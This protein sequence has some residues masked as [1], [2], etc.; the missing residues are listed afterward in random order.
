MTTARLSPRR[1][2][3]VAT[4]VESFVWGVCLSSMR[5][6]VCLASPLSDEERVDKNLWIIAGL[7]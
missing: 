3:Q 2:V 4:L 1:I 5:A 7:N 6:R